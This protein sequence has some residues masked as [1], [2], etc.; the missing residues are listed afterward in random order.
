[1]F[2]VMTPCRLAGRYVYPK[3]WYLPASLHGVMTQ[4]IVILT[5]ETKHGYVVFGLSAAM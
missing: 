3:G 5:G 1:M 2:W 4:N